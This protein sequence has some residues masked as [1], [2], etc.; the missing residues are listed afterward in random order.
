MLC[1]SMNLIPVLM[2]LTVLSHSPYKSSFVFFSN[3]LL[4]FLFT[5]ETA[6]GVISGHELGTTGVSKLTH[7]AALF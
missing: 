6:T 5:R 1:V 3:D 4:L 7:T 2:W